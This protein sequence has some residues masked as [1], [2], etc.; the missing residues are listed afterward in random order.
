[1]INGLRKVFRKNGYT[2]EFG[3]DTGSIRFAED[4]SGDRFFIEIWNSDEQEAQRVYISTSDILAIS[5]MGLIT[6]CFTTEELLEDIP[7]IVKKNKDRDRHMQEMAE[8]RDE[9]WR[10]SMPIELE[11]DYDAAHADLPGGDGTPE[12]FAIE[13][14]GVQRLANGDF[15]IRP[16]YK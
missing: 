14:W 13:G 4:S 10:P 2:G 3:T 8:K 16:W 11:S 12:Y 6:E 5:Q 9:M 1:M 7:K 15:E